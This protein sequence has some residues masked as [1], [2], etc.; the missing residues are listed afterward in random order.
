MQFAER[1][2]EN[3]KVGDY[4]IKSS[5]ET[6][7]NLEI[8]KEY[9][10]SWTSYSQTLVQRVEVKN[11]VEYINIPK[12]KNSLKYSITGDDFKEGS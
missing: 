8:G 9:M 7:L 4:S 1:Y 12:S 11:N 10:L 3:P 5:G 2:V 6:I